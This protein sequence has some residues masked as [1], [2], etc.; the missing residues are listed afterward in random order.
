MQEDVQTVSDR[1]ECLF[2]L[3]LFG[4]EFCLL[5]EPIVQCSTAP[6]FRRV[7]IAEIIPKLAPTS[8]PLLHSP[9]FGDNGRPGSTELREFPTDSYFKNYLEEVVEMI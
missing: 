2:V 9:G 4:W 3:D 7:G 8:M 6:L 1:I 5:V